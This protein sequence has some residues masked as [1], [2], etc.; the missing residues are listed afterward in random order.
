VSKNIHQKLNDVMKAIHYI[1]KDAVV[2]EGRSSYKA[3]THDQVT[4]QTREEFV[5][6][7]I[8]VVTSLVEGKT[9]FIERGKDD[10]GN[11][12]HPI[13]F[14]DGV[15]D[16]EFVNIDDPNDKIVKRVAGH[17]EDCGDKA[18]G[19][20][21]SI[22]QKRAVLKQL[23]IETGE[24][25]E[26]RIQHDQEDDSA[27]RLAPFLADIAKAPSR[28]AIQAIS[29]AYVE[30]AKRD[31]WGTV[32]TRKIVQEACSKR[33]GVIAESAKAEPPK[34]GNAAKE[35]EPTKLNLPDDPKE[36]AKVL[37]AELDR[38]AEKQAA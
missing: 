37:Q 14:F 35:D 33:A 6:I 4:A 18:P 7:G 5:G 16:V 2:G 26:S 19:K 17:G 22:A 9:T 20:A 15:F 13:V 30:A 34:K 27:D 21:E 29:K 36:A 38:R 1:K 32:E 24:N 11:Q 23:Q 12:K 31:G 25:D 28:E 10:R 3:V 8:S